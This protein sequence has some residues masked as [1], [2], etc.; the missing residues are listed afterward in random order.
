MELKANNI[1]EKVLGNNEEI[2]LL[3]KNINNSNES[4]AWMLK[5]PKGIGKSFLLKLIC[6][7]ILNIENN[8]EIA[9]AKFY[10]P[11]LIVLQ[12]ESDKKNIPVEEVRKVRKFFSKT[13]FSGNARI[14]LIDSI[15]D[16]NTHGHNSLLKIIEEPPNNSFI[17]IV[18]HMNSYVPLTVKS[19]CRSYNFRQL[20][21]SVTANILRLHAKDRS[22]NEILFCASLSKGSAGEAIKLLNSNA[23]NTYK[24]LCF[25]LNNINKLDN[26]N[27]I[28]YLE[29]I[30]KNKLNLGFLFFKLLIYLFNKAI[31]I[32][33]LNKEDFILN[34]E[35]KTIKH[36]TKIYNLDDFFNLREI[37][38]DSFLN[39]SL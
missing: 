31:K 16:L 19:R 32:K 21:H 35:E 33:A 39:Y 12:K 6:T 29:S 5:G 26:I 17:F 1:I 22:E 30:S 20:D 36:L 37:I 18:N 3:I 27:I 2:N 8:F 13:S 23:L 25:F 11:D 9:K 7:K 38:N 34:E 14:A 15:N 10:H 24:E 28:E 4:R